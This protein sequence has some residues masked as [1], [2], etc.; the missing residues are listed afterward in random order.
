LA[1]ACSR[2]SASQY[3]REARTGRLPVALGVSTDYL[4][5]EDALGDQLATITELSDADR[6]MLLSFLDALITRTRLKRLIERLPATTRTPLTGKK[7]TC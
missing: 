6:A 5:I 4:L 7:V 2:H 3:R 1:S